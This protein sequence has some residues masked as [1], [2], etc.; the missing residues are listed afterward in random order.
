MVEVLTWD[1]DAMASRRVFGEKSPS[2][3][4]VLLALESFDSQGVTDRDRDR[5][6]DV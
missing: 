1:F 2:L 4:F 6:R 3:T 5:D